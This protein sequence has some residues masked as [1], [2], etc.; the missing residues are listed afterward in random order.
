MLWDRIYWLCVRI[1]KCLFFKIER[2]KININFCVICDNVIMSSVITVFITWRASLADSREYFVLFYFN[3]LQAR[4]VHT[5]GWTSCSWNLEAISGE[6]HSIY[7]LLNNINSVVKN[8]CK[9]L[10][11]L[12]IFVALGRT[13]SRA[14]SLIE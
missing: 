14:L 6:P 13:S 11:Y 8:I 10:I 12:K 1:K 4:H 9:N 7:S 5:L 3:L 2:K